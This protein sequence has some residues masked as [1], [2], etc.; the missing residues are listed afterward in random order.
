MPRQTSLF[1][2]VRFEESP[3]LAPF[4]G[5]TRDLVTIKSSVDL[6]K[7]IHDFLLST[8]GEWPYLD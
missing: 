7:D 2:G 1:K 4:L 8:S 6:L 5:I 3:C